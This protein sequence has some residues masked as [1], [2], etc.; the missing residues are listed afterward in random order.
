MGLGNPGEDYSGTR[1][2][3]GFMVVNRVSK[4]AGEGRWKISLHSRLREVVLG[5]RQ[6]VLVK[7][8]TFVN[9]SGTAVTAVKEHYGLPPEDILV[10]CDDANLPPGRIRIRRKG[11]S[12]GHRGL[13][14]IIDTLGTDLFP[15]LRVGIGAPP[16]GVEMRDFVLAPFKEEEKEIMKRAVQKACTAALKWVEEGIES[17]MNEFNS[18]LSFDNDRED[19]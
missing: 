2:N 11:S 6:V 17:A 10:V 19:L 14:S 4:E 12:G 13:Q 18:A 16:P 3:V 15:R 8:R 7:P 9:D 1:H 5:E